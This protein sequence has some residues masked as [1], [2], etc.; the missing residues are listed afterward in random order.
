MKGHK[1]LMGLKLSSRSDATPLEVLDRAALLLFLRRSIRSVVLPALR[2]LRQ[3]RL[4]VHI[5][6]LTRLG[7]ATI[8]IRQSVLASPLRLA[9][10]GQQAL[11]V[12]LGRAPQCHSLEM[13][14]DL[15][16]P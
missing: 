16:N 15:W 1:T 9:V 10:P 3:L 13:R 6:L 14:R 11:V 4:A 8:R 5:Y 12:G 7:Q 2:P